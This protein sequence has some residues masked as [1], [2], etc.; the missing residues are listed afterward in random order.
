MHKKCNQKPRRPIE[1]G[2][3]AQVV[4]QINPEVQ[5]HQGCFGTLATF[6]TKPPESCPSWLSDSHAR[7]VSL[8]LCPRTGTDSATPEALGREKTGRVLGSRLPAPPS[9]A[10]PRP[11]RPRRV[12]PP[13]KRGAGITTPFGQPRV[14]TGH[15]HDETGAFGRDKAATN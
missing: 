7:K 10:P 3:L 14:A 4:Y 11:S 9:P 1:M 12:P 15:R 5:G 13:S 2:K 6:Q 8:S